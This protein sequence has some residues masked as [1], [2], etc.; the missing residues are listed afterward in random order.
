MANKKSN[1]PNA[2]QIAAEPG[3]NGA[4]VQRM[5]ELRGLNRPDTDEAVEQRVKWFFEWCSTN[6]VR[7]ALNFW[8][9]HLGLQDKIFGYGSRGAIGGDSSLQWLNRCWRR[10]WSNG[11][12]LGK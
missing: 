12:K 2:Q 6:D 10:F 4:M 11:E 8:R 1:F 7:P 3:E 9:W 5:E